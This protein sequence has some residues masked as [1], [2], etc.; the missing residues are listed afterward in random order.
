[1]PSFSIVAYLAACNTLR[2]KY[3]DENEHIKYSPLV[4]A[5]LLHRLIYLMLTIS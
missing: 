5:S 3:E 4:S 2:G 1:M